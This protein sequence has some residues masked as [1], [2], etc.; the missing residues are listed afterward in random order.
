MAAGETTGFVTFANNSVS[1]SFSQTRDVNT[2]V[3]IPVSMMDDLVPSGEDILLLKTD[4]QGY[5]LSVLKGQFSSLQGA[6]FLMVEFSCSLMGDVGTDPIELLHFIYDRGF[7][8]THMAYIIPNLSQAHTILSK[9]SP[10]LPRIQFPSLGSWK[11]YAPYHHQRQ[12]GSPAGLISCVHALM[13]SVA[14][15][16][17]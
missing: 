6:H 13:G 10:F 15:H 4:T 1:T 5:E 14:K 9:N 7:V 12:L 17:L 16:N 2:G 8:C 3:K 11:V